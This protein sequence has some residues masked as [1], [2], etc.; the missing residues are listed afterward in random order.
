MKLFSR[1]RSL[2]K[3]PAAGGE[4]HNPLPDTGSSVEYSNRA[5]ASAIIRTDVLYKSGGYSPP[6]SAGNLWIMIKTCHAFRVN[7]SDIYLYIGINVEQTSQT[8]PRLTLPLQT[9]H[10]VSL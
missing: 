10:T 7:A 3:S 1:L 6:T 9:V 8:M 5:L 2:I 4:R